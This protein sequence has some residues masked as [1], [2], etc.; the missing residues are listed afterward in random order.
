MIEDFDHA[1]NGACLWKS[2]GAC[3][4][5]AQMRYGYFCSPEHRDDPE[6]GAAK[7]PPD[8]KEL[9][10]LQEKFLLAACALGTVED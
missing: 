7:L 5:P 8:P 10:A 4:M 3:D 6:D 9:E 2:P 1:S